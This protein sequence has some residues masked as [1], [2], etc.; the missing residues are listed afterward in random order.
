MAEK[1]GKA[2]KV[3]GVHPEVLKSLVRTCNAHKTD[4]DEAR[5]ELGAAVKNAEDAHGIHRKA[6]K[7]CLSLD[8]ME[9]AARADFLRAFDDY[10]GKLDLNPQ[11]DMFDEGGDEAQRRAEQEAKAESDDR[12]A[13][14]GKALKGGIKQLEAVH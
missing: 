12:A 7:L 9:D 1:M 5:G 10:R 8:R 6:F 11:P 3:T 13:E 4:M 2:A 14:N